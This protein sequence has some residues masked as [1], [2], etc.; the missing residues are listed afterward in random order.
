MIL[1]KRILFQ[2]KTTCG[3]QAKLVALAPSVI[4]LWL[5][6]LPLQ[7]E[8]RGGEVVY[9]GLLLHNKCLFRKHLANFYLNFLSLNLTKFF[10][11]ALQAKFTTNKVSS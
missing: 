10:G 9:A 3:K 7:G 1:N 11:F 4:N 5:I 6:T 2:D 8:G